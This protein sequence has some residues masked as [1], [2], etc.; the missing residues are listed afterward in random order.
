MNKKVSI[1]VPVYNSEKYLERCIDSLIN[2]SYHNIEIILINDGSSDNSLDILRK[3]SKLDKRIIIINQLNQGSNIARKK[4][5]DYSTG[6]YIMFVDSDDWIELD[7]VSVLIKLLDKLEYDVIKFNGILEPT[8]MLKNN[9]NLD[10]SKKELNKNEIYELLISTKVLNNLCF[11]IYNAKKL[12]KIKSFDVN[13][14]NCEDYL[15]N[16]EYYTS[17]DKMLMIDNILYHYQINPLS[18]TKNISV[19]KIKTNI[20]ELIFVYEKLFDYLKKWKINTYKNQVKV[21][22]NVLDSFKYTI[23]NLLL[24]DKQLDFLNELLNNNILIY[25]RNNYNYS[26]I[27]LELSKKPLSYKLKHSMIIK[28]IYFKNY[29]IILLYKYLLRIKRVFV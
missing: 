19:D 12:K 1:I 6:E 28:S 14:S 23:Y 3:Y 7:A 20:L 18:T 29:R 2:Q 17:V 5:L 27:K 24:Y 25:I 13:I 8:K 10:I 11:S 9:Y 4:G 22:F 26:D 15:V 21:S 16:L